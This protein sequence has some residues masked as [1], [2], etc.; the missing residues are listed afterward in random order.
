MSGINKVVLVGNLDRDPVLRSNGDG[1]RF[2]HFTLT[3]TEEWQDSTGQARRRQEWH[4]VV[5]TNDRMLETVERQLRKG[6]NIYI[7][8]QVQTRKWTKDGVDRYV[9]EV[10]MKPFRSDLV[11]LDSSGGGPPP[12]ESYD[13]YGAR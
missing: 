12:V 2:A 5:V 10:V 3:T 11:L 4:R 6:S 8:G 13:E 7:E 1:R 9:T